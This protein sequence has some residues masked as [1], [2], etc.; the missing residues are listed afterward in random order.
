[1][2]ER[3]CVDDSPFKMYMEISHSRNELELADPGE[4][5]KGGR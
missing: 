1:M 5:R 3:S 2:D 4:R